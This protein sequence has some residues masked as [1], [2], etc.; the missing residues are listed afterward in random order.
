MQ[1]NKQQY[2][3]MFILYKRLLS[4]PPPPSHRCGL[5]EFGS[6]KDCCIGNIS[7]LRV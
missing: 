6:A 2:M 1:E 4:Q 5:E 3:I 7:A